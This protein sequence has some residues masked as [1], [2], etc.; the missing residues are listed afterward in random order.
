VTL[1]LAPVADVNV[2]PRNPVIGLRA[3]SADA[4]VAARHV[5]A[6]VQGIQASG[7]AACLKHF[8]G[9]GATRADSHHEV[10]TLART[11]EELDTVEFV[12]FRAGIAAGARAVMTGHLLVPALDAER[13]ATVSSQVTTDILRGR[14]GFSG[15]VVTDALEMRAI[16]A[17][18][19]MV[20]GFVQALRAG[21]DTIETGAL[22]YP[23]LVAAIPRAVRAALDAGVL[24]VSRLE[25]AARRTEALARP[26]VPTD[27]PPL[28]DCAVARCLEVRGALPRLERPMVIECRTPGGMASGELPWSLGEPLAELV[29]GT[30]VVRTT[31]PV[32]V[33]ADRDVVLV[34]R[35]P[36]RHTWQQ[37]LLDATMRHPNAVV[38]DSGWPADIEG[39]AVVRTR[40]V[41]PGLL[42]AAAR[43]LAAGGTP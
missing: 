38:V 32:D 6:A 41:A 14:L 20:D 9:H 25:D 18:V 17:T 26:A 12:P 35:D 10:A 22:D 4:A 19:G 30:E 34:V 33:P 15:T 43:T 39:V 28:D 31:G 2:D 37:P 40:G 27:A 42:R 5:A 23:E 7:V 21:A 1:D 29:P 13:V 16:S 24:D 36:Q 3:F 8:P 11:P